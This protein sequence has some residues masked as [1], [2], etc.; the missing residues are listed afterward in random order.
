MGG[1][2][3]IEIFMNHKASEPLD[4]I[5]PT[6]DD[7][8]WERV[9]FDKVPGKLAMVKAHMEKI[10]EALED[11]YTT[12]RT[13]SEQI[14]LK[15]QKRAAQHAVGFHG[16]IGDYMLVATYNTSAERKL[17]GIW[18]GPYQLVAHY[19]KKVEVLRT[20]V[21]KKKEFHMHHRRLKRYR[22]MYCE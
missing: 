18:R 20:I 15:N 8:T 21:D 5:L 1:Y 14:Q 19:N 6:G 17:V 13:C 3:P 2:A 7:E 11:A 12:V 4:V 16:D 22:V 9:D 10:S